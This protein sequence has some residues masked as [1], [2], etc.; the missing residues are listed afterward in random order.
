MVWKILL[1]ILLSLFTVI[2]FNL[3]YIFVLDK[4]RINKW[5][6]LVLGVLLIGFS[7]FLMGTKLHIILKLLAIVISVMPFMWFYNIV[8][9]E[10]Y[11]KKTNPKIKIKPK[12]K[13]NRVK[14]TKK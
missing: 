6:V 8:N 7:T 4:L 10:K 13:P 3:L 11:E 9:K 2:T 14:S 1:L 5:I 12:A